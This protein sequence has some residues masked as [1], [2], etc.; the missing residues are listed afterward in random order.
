MHVQK[1]VC[2]IRAQPH[3]T[4]V[5]E[6]CINYSNEHRI[7]PLWLCEEPIIVF[8]CEPTLKPPYKRNVQGV[9]ERKHCFSVSV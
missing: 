4:D 3:T 1:P 5:S 7:R 6:S 9:N 8:F 2:C